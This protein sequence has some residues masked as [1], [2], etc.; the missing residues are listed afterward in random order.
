MGSDLMPA[1][2]VTGAAGGVAMSVPTA[3]PAEPKGVSLGFYRIEI[4]K[5]GE[6]IPPK[7][8]SETM[9]GIGVL[10]DTTGTKLD[11]AY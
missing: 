4:T 6:S 8:N 9:L 11:L 10:G 7:Y 2:G 5:E 3:G 1:T